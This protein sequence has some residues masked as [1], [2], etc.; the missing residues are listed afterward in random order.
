[1]QLL[2]GERPGVA[3][4]AER[5]RRMA[6]PNVQVTA[7]GTGIMFEH[8]VAVVVR[9][10]TALRVNVFRPPKEGRFPVLVS[11]HPYGKD[12]LPKRTPLGYAPVKRYRF[13]RQPERVTFSALT[14]WEAP[15]PSHWVP[16]GYV[17]V[18][19]DLRGFG[20]SD[21]VGAILSDQE[22]DDY[23]QVIEWAGAQPWSTGKVALIG[24]SYLA[25]SQWKAAALRPN[26]LAAICPW[27]GFT[28]CYHDVAY[29]AG[30][31]EDG[32]MPLWS[33]QL[34]RAGRTSVS[35]RRE[36]L[37]R[38]LRDDFWAAAS[39]ALERIEVPA[40]I[41]A[42]FSDHGLHT[43]GSFEAFRRVGSKDRFLYTHRGGKWS[44]FY[45]PNA[46]ELQA[47]FFDCYLKGFDNGMRQT[48]P[49]R[50][51]VRASGDSAHEVRLE[52][53]WPLPSTQW[54]S[55][56]L[57]PRALRSSPL[58]TSATT[59]F[60]ARKGRASFVMPVLDDFE[61]SGPM[62]LRLHVELVGA[63]DVNLFVAVRKLA[64]SGRHVVFEG[65]FGFG[66]DVVSKGWLRVALRRLDEVHSEL[67]RPVHSCEREEPLEPGRI[68]RVDIE[69]L[70]SAT[71]FRRGEAMRLDV[72]GRWF[73]PK[74]PL[75]G[76]FPV[77]Y[78]PS[79][80]GEVVLHLGGEYDAHLL[81][82]LTAGLI[83]GL[84]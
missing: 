63:R 1:M 21:G 41:C 22:A 73:W 69:L 45:S 43:R 51:E 9:D 68:A 29:P 75:I 27:E 5:L 12:V 70:P 59:R 26:S 28:D 16:R 33:D 25:I 79:A 54:K 39:P 82:P 53:G 52:R 38:P 83:R 62:T 81:V 49:V 61:L 15:D 80:G 20:A 44:T 34:D 24:V 8:D 2:N 60:P 40:L 30:V 67:Y 10:G 64:D 74:N 36:Q 17:V 65:A 35:L 50:L 56:H 11:A 57:G 37:A 66:F 14:S 4:A 71:L 72:Q 58:S 47:R 55:L 78:A 6:F 48:A 18:N 46:L 13:I 31:R 23:A 42:S 76:T 3:Y 7:P 32:F 84:E 19:V 77:D